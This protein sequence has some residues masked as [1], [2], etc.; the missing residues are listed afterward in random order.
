MAG[1]PVMTSDLPVFREVVGDAALL[2]DPRSL[3]AIAKAMRTA[4]TDPDLL[5][6]LV[7]RG[8]ERAAYFTWDRT[9]EGTLRTFETALAQGPRRQH[10]D[11]SGS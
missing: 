1:V 9:A 2:F 7:E 4:V 8:Y 11:G 5:A 10:R 6:R 3:P